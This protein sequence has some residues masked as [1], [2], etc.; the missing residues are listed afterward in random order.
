[1]VE[2]NRIYPPL[3]DLDTFRLQQSTVSL[4]TLEKELDAREKILKKYK[5]ASSVLSKTCS[6]SGTISFALTGSGLWVS[7][8]G[9]GVPLGATLAAVGGLCGIMSVVTGLIAKKIAPDSVSMN[10][11]PQFA[12]QRSTR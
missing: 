2:Y 12:P 7:L 9:V 8:T 10:R 5:R 4:S 11:L 1:M 3:S 6:G